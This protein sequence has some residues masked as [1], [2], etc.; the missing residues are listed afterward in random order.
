[1]EVMPLVMVACRPNA[2]DSVCEGDARVGVLR[3]ELDSG[4]LAAVCVAVAVGS[5]YG[6]GHELRVQCYGRRSP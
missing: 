5:C 3:A 6:A 4:N 1:M 2:I